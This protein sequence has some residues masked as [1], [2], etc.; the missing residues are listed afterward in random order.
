MSVRRN[1]QRLVDTLVEISQQRRRDGALDADELLDAATCFLG[2]AISLEDD[3]LMTAICIAA[4][5][6]QLL[7]VVAYYAGGGPGNGRLQ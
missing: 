5:R 1:V 2:I 7:S 6:R 4:V 3:P